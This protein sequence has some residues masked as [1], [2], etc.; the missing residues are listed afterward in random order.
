MARITALHRNKGRMNLFLDGEF[1][2]SLSV[3]LVSREGL[4]NDQI[5]SSEQVE[6][7]VKLDCYQRCLVTATRFLSLRP[8]SDSELRTRLQRG[9]FDTQ[10][11]D[12]VIGALKDKGLINDSIFAQYW[13]ENR[14]SFSPRSRRLTRIELQKKG[15]DREVIDQVVS[16]IDDE[17]SAYRAVSSH[18]RNVR[19]SDRDQF[20]RRLGGYLERRG[21][22]Y[23]VIES[24]LKKIW[25]E[26]Q[27]EV[28]S[29]TG[30][31]EN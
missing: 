27:I 20:R 21:F 3:T 19:W 8:R 18:A 5:I 29:N 1:A 30:E 9:G 12:S 7:L 17:T 6:S 16:T 10:T 26:L 15:I 23:G 28:N 13:T 25:K 31:M 4:H 14:E 22:G 11:Q 2:F 24:T